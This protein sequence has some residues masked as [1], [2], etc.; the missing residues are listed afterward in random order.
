M[1]TQVTF[2][3]SEPTQLLFLHLARATCEFHS[4]FPVTPFS[5]AQRLFPRSH[6]SGAVLAGLR[7]GHEPGRM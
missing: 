3:P 5:S 4:C 6:P 7:G 2:S 1:D